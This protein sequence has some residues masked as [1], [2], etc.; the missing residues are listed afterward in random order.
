M[1]LLVDA[2][3]VTIEVVLRIPRRKKKV[4]RGIMDLGGG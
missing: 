1:L 3:L 2:K 4:A